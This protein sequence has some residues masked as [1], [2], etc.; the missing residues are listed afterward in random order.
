MK[1]FRESFISCLLIFIITVCFFSVQR[2]QATPFIPR[3]AVPSDLQSLEHSSEDNSE[4]GSGE[5]NDVQ[6]SSME[7]FNSSSS[8]ENTLTL[9]ESKSLLD[10]N[11]VVYSANAFENLKDLNDYQDYIKNNKDL[12]NQLEL[13]VDLE[14]KIIYA[15]YTDQARIENH[16]ILLYVE[17]NSDNETDIKNFVDEMLHLYP[18]LLVRGEEVPNGRK[19]DSVF[20]INPL[21]KDTRKLWFNDQLKQ[22]VYEGERNQFEYSY[23][24]QDSDM[25]RPVIEKYFPGLFEFSS[26]EEGSSVKVRVKPIIQSENSEE[27][28]SE[29]NHVR[30]TRERSSTFLER[31]NLAI[32]NFFDR[33][34]LRSLLNK[35]HIKEEYHLIVIFG[36]VLFLI[37]VGVMLFVVSRR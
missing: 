23:K 29:N 9:D 25:Y 32:T 2:V 35:F 33:I 31:V 16:P 6:I 1:I 18:D 17:N 7:N 30:R 10:T 28:A 5:N 13:K 22:I 20:S 24:K 12:M 27:T 4:N 15:N 37:L 34:D 19:F 21:V 11:I 3:P 26:K 14:K 8:S 36:I